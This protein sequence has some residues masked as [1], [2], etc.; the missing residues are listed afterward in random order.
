MLPGVVERVAIAAC[1]TEDGRD[2]Y[3]DGDWPSLR[4]ALRVE[5]LSATQVA[6]DDIAVDWSRYDVVVIRST[7][8]SVVRPREYVRWVREAQERTR[9]HNP[10]D[11][12]EWNLDKRHLQELDRAGLPVVPTQ[13]VEPGHE[14]DMPTEPFV[15]KPTISGGGRDTARYD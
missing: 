13:W 4:D 6:W 7:W 3:P 5:G 12:I 8:D 10:A 11:V 9:L 15:V 1:H 2:I 14:W